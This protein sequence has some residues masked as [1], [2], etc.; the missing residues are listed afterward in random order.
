MGAFDHGRKLPVWLHLDGLVDDAGENFGFGRRVAQ[1]GDNLDFW[2]RRLVKKH[3]LRNDLLQKS[4]TLRITVIADR[5]RCAEHIGGVN[6]WR[7]AQTRVL[8][9]RLR[10][11]GNGQHNRLIDQGLWRR[12]DRN[13]LFRSRRFVCAHLTVTQV[14]RVDSGADRLVYIGRVS[15]AP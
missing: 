2:R 4:G 6:E 12:R 14:P 9:Q 3:I 15:V 7:R 10:D 11:L 1:K 8:V 13:G 5:A